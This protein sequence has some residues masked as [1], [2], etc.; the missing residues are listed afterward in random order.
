MDYFIVKSRLPA[1][2]DKEKRKKKEMS[3]FCSVH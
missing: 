2:L 3:L 1:L